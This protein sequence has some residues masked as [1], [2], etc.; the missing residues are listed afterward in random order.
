[1]DATGGVLD[2]GQT[3]LHHDQESPDIATPT[4]FPLKTLS[5][6]ANASGEVGRGLALDHHALGNPGKG[7][8]TRFECAMF[9]APTLWEMRGP[10]MRI[11]FASVE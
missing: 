4:Q 6:R 10:R 9:D 11:G 5:A 2:I 8:V 3:P 1:M 7:D